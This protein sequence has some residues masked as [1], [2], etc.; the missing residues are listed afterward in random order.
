MQVGIGYEGALLG[1]AWGWAAEEP[2]GLGNQL[3][4]KRKATSNAPTL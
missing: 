4:M 1:V 2:E 3:Q